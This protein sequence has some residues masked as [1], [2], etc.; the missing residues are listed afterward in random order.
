MGPVLLA[1]LMGLNDTQ[2]CVLTIAF[3]FADEQGLLL[4]DLAAL[5]AMLAHCAE[6]AQALSA[7]YGNVS[8]AT[9]VAINRPSLQL[10]SPGGAKF[11]WVPATD[12]AE[13][14]GNTDQETA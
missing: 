5:Q 6:N 7:E 4:L 3:R 14:I 12:N 9:V 2:E 1:R 8:K 11:L 10:E 13:F